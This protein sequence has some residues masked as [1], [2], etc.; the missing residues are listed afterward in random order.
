M[1]VVPVV[2]EV[3]VAEQLALPPAPAIVHVEG[4]RLP[5]T[6]EVKLIV[7]VGV[8]GLGLV[9]VTVAM[10]LEAWPT[11]MLLG[12]HETLVVVVSTA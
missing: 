1:V 11:T 5:S 9:S 7:P 6:D 12:A 3:K 8:I 2:D 4:D 10:Q